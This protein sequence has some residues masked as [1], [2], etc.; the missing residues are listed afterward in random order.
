[1]SNFDEGSL[2]FG[3][4]DYS[5]KNIINPKYSSALDFFGGLAA[6]EINSN[7]GFINKKGIIKIKPIYGEV[8]SFSDGLA[9]V[10]NN[11][12]KWGFINKEGKQI[13]NFQFKDV[14]NF[15]EE[16]ASVKDFEDKWHLIDKKGKFI[17]KQSF[18]SIC[19]FSDGVACAKVNDKFGFIDKI[20]NFVIKP[21]F[22]SAQNFNEGLAPVR[23]KVEKLTKQEIKN[24]EPIEEMKNALQLKTIRN[25]IDKNE[26]EKALE[27]IKN[28]KTKNVELIA[29][30][31]IYYNQAYVHIAHNLM[32]NEKISEQDKIIK[33]KENLEEAKI[34]ILSAKNYYKKPEDL[35]E[36]IHL[37][38][39][40]NELLKIIY[41]PYLALL[42]QE[43]K[44]EKV[45]YEGQKL[46]KDDPKNYDAL[47]IIGVAKFKSGDKEEGIKL[48]K[49]SIE[50]EPDN[51]LAYYNLS[52]LYSLSKQVDL[53][54]NNLNKS[55]SLNPEVKKMAKEDKDFD[56]IKEN[57]QF[58]KIIK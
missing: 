49:K 16:I 10:K 58:K 22:E 24:S 55:I 33:I 8:N 21:T 54:M 35:S 34:H 30:L 15:S 7:W 46:I 36:V 29:L 12:N 56:N 2:H 14:N 50:V 25:F 40:T 26:P 11:Q 5:G 17:S 48:I 51:Y 9:A 3:Y 41:I 20:G 13:I 28:I 27:I 19:E 37:E 43:K 6:V 4:I 39:D 23:V 18:S 44:Y 45:T 1:M 47:N 32:E 52:C 42:S 57:E 38:K 31:N 53:S